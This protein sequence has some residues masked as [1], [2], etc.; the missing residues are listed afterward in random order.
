MLHQSSMLTSALAA[1]LCAHTDKP[2]PATISSS[3]ALQQVRP[4]S[5][6]LSAPLALA[7]GDLPHRKWLVKASPPL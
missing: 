5:V 7:A 2:P 3:R 6:N 4:D 1:V